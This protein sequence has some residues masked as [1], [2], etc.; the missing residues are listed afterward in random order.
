MHDDV[1]KETMI[2]IYAN[3]AVSMVQA[4]LQV[5]S[6]LIFCLYLDPKFK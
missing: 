4:Y 6:T 3:D 5:W 1:A 2:V